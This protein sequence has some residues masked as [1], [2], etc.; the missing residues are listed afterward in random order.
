MKKEINL[1]KVEESKLSKH[2]KHHSRKHI[3]EM[4][5]AMLRGRS[6]NAAHGM[7]MDKVGK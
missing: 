1:T 4:I 6:F 5:K 2:K 7:A 3:R